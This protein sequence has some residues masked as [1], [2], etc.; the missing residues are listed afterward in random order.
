MEKER[1]GMTNSDTREWREWE[2]GRSIED[3]GVLPE[4]NMCIRRNKISRGSVKHVSQ[5]AST[6]G[7]S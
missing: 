3:N 7:I 2:R 6:C 5:C 4:Y 1:K